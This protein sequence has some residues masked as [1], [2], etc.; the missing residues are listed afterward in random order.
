M[1]S[2][3]FFSSLNSNADPVPV[4]DRSSVMIRTLHVLSIYFG[5]EVR[6]INDNSIPVFPLSESCYITFSASEAHLPGGLRKSDA[7]TTTAMSCQLRHRHDLKSQ[8]SGFYFYRVPTILG[9]APSSPICYWL[10]SCDCGSGKLSYNFNFTC[11][12]SWSK[13]L[14]LLQTHSN[15][16]L[17]LVNANALSHVIE[18]TCS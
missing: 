11:D 4:I 7:N 15:Q 17:P 5:A 13:L 16:R 6:Q 9:A 12:Y 18:T 1:L 3:S 2:F 8:I 10:N 14:G